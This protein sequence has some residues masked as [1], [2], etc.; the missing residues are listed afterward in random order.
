MPVYKSEFS[1]PT[2]KKLTGALNQ[3]VASAGE[4]Q[5]SVNDAHKWNDTMAFY[6]E[7]PTVDFKVTMPKALPQEN[8]TPLTISVPIKLKEFLEAKYQDKLS[9]TAASILSQMAEGEA[10][11]IPESDLDRLSSGERGL[12]QR[13]KNSSELCGLIYAKMCEVSD[14]KAEKDEAVKD[15]KAYE[16]LSQG[17]VVLDLGPLYPTVVQKAKEAELPLKLYIETNFKSAIENNWF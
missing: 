6:N 2:C 16:G 7:N 9:A 14:A 15:L 3:I 4:L 17:R 13:P 12:G 11:I 5:C 10:M 1:C 8:H